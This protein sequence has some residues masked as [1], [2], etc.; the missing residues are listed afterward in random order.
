MRKH[1]ESLLIKFVF[2]FETPDTDPIE[3]EIDMLQKEADR[4]GQPDLVDKIATEEDAM[5]E[6]EVAEFLAQKGHPAAALEMML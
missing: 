2:E 6:E 4:I 3:A 5:T 1:L